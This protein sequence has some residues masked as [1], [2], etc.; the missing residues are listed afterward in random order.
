MISKSDVI[1]KMQS[2]V[3]DFDF[4]RLYGN[5][6]GA[7]GESDKKD[8]KDKKKDTKNQSNASEQQLGSSQDGLDARGDPTGKKQ[9]LY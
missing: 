4:E 5:G 9:I 7:A 2:I 6:P 3:E 1:Q 8:S